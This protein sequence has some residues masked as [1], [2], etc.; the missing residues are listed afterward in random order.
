[1]FHRTGICTA[2][3]YCRSFITYLRHVSMLCHAPMLRPLPILRHIYMLPHVLM[4]HVPPLH[5][6]PMLRYVPT[7]CHVLMLRHVLMWLCLIAVV[8]ACDFDTMHSYEK[9]ACSSWLLPPAT[10]GQAG[11]IRTSGHKLDGLTGPLVDYTTALPTGECNCRG[12]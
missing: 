9:V 3:I 7:L 1:M 4:R 11:F 5:H 12:G 6:I 10:D 2:A 8:H